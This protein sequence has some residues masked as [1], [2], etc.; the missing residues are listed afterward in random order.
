MTFAAVL[1]MHSGLY[2]GQRSVFPSLGM[3]LRVAAF[4]LIGNSPFSRHRLMGPSRTSGLSSAKS[5]IISAGM[6]S[7]PGLLPVLSFIAALFSSSIVKGVGLVSWLCVMKAIGGWLGKS[8]RS[9]GSAL[10]GV[11]VL[12]RGLMSFIAKRYASPHGLLLISLQSLSC[13]RCFAAF[14]S[15]ANS[16]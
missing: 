6:P 3:S 7:G 4:H 9:T 15:S 2:F 5:L 16:M 12:V 8:F 1:I 14:F 11:L 10:W 13:R